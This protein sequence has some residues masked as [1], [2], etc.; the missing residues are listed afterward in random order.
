MTAR[1][2]AEIASRA[3]EAA[4]AVL[5]DTWHAPRRI[6]HKSEVDLVTDADLAAEAAALAVIRDACPDDAIVTEE[7][8]H[9]DG[10]SPRRWIVDPLD[11]TT[12]FAHGHPHLAVSV[13]V[14]VDGE[15]VAGAVGD[16]FRR[17][18][19]RAARG[20]GAWLN[21][22]R[23][24]VSSVGSLDEALVATGFPYDRREAPARY[25]AFVERVL[26]ACQ[27]IRR[28]GSAALDLAWLAAGRVDA[29]WE[30]KLGP[31]DVAAGRLLVTEAGGIVT[32]ADGSPHMLAGPST[33]AS[34]GLVHADLLRTLA[35]DGSP[36]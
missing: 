13:A 3:V 5:R 25:L 24:A 33:V 34:N 8:G 18:L 29:F 11:G 26:R 12:N 2:L 36:P 15:I 27:G 32:A 35:W 31:W 19:F 14:E 1:A 23:L 20:D 7:S 21:G 16:P 10:S 9:L 4:A 28:A 6:R 17:E 30:W 22:A